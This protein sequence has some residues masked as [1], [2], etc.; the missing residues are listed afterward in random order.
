[1]K[2]SEMDQYQNVNFQDDD[3]SEISLLD[4]LYHI[5]RRWRSIVLFAV[6]FCVLLGGFKLAKGIRALGSTDL[7]DE[8]KNYESQLKGYTIS[9]EHLENQIKELTESIQDKEDYYDHSVLMKLDPKKSYKGTVTFVVTDAGEVPAAEENRDLSLAIDRKMNSVL[10]SYVALIQNGTILRDVQNELTSKID[11]KYLAELIYTQVDYQS[12]LLHITVVG[13]DKQQVQSISDAIVQGLQNASVQMNASVA[14]HRLELLTSY[15]GNDADTS[16]PVGMIPEAGAN[17][18]DASYQTSIEGIQKSYTNSITD[19]QNQLLDCNNQL[20]E[21][22]EPEP[23]VGASRGSVLKEGI[24]Y[25]IIGFI[26]GAFVLAFVYALQYLLCGK[27]MDSDEL[28]DRYGVLLLGDYHAPLHAHPNGIDRWIDR[29][30]GITEEKRS[31]ESVYALS[32]A[33][34]VAQV[35]AEKNPKI[36][37]MG[38]AKSEDFDAAAIA[39]SEKLRSSGIDVIAAGNVNESAPAIEKLQQAEQVVLIEQRGASRQQDIQ[40]EILT[41]RKL[42]KKIVGAI[43]L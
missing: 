42:E 20:S 23:P 12:K 21:L 31:V 24:K 39:L 38:N 5:L 22:E 9:K 43:I 27:L 18:S 4:L 19:M 2:E 16:I 34:I 26:V 36:L 40:K 15:V 11:Q 29:M 33:N 3:E 13:A 25:G 41:L 37:L 17:T 8:Q 14:A 7:K 35:G 28:N 30:N 32:A 6:L 1:M 10:G